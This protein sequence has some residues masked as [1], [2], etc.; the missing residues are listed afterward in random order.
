VFENLRML[1]KSFQLNIYHS[2]CRAVYGTENI[3]WSSSVTSRFIRQMEARRC[4]WIH[5][6]ELKNKDANNRLREIAAVLESDRREMEKKIYNCKAGR[7]LDRIGP[8]RY[9]PARIRRTSA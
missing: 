2:L 1:V 5:N 7:S 8:A 9:S 3:E 4:L 6:P